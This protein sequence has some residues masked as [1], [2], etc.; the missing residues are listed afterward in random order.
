MG[1]R[2]GMNKSRR[3][4]EKTE[5]KLQHHNGTMVSRTNS[6]SN[7]LGQ[8]KSTDAITDNGNNIL[9]VI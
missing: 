5:N 9:V 1:S 4:V 3:Q 6:N 7:I 2:G 8:N